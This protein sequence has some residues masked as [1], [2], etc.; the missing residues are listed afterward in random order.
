[1]NPCYWLHVMLHRHSGPSR[2]EFSLMLCFHTYYCTC[3]Y[4][5]YLGMP[6]GASLFFLYFLFIYLFFIYSSIGTTGP[7]WNPLSRSPFSFTFN[8]SK[9]RATLVWGGFLGSVPELAASV[10]NSVSSNMGCTTMDV[11]RKQTSV[12]LAWLLISFSNLILSSQNLWHRSEMKTFFAEFP[13]FLWI[14]C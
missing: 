4:C 10:S 1:M 14:S 8:N 6:L 2:P 11:Q 7:Q 5:M 12:L 13:L 3:N 9:G